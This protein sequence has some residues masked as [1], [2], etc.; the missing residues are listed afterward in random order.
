MAR[1]SVVEYLPPTLLH[2]EWWALLMLGYLWES[3][4]TDSKK[5]Q[6]WDKVKHLM[7]G[8]MDEFGSDVN[9]DNVRGFWKGKEFALLTENEKREILWE[10]AEM[11]FRLEIHSLNHRT[12]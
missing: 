2:Q 1:F 3:G 9:V 5:A 8:C 7:A 4:N 12:S 10:V 11:G 6:V